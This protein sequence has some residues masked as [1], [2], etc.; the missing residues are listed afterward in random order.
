MVL[1]LW[2]TV[3]HSIPVLIISNCHFLRIYSTGFNAT[4]IKLY[5]TV[6]PYK[7]VFYSS[8][9][10][11]AS[12]PASM[13]LAGTETTIAASTARSAV[14]PYSVWWSQPLKSIQ[15]HPAPLCSLCWSQDPQPSASPYTVPWGSF[16]PSSPFTP[17][18]WCTTTAEFCCQVHPVM[19]IH[20]Q[21]TARWVQIQIFREIRECSLI[22]MMGGLVIFSKNIQ[23]YAPPL[24]GI[25]DQ[26]ASFNQPNLNGHPPVEYESGGV[27]QYTFISQTC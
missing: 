14:H 15:L 16:I 23:D 9:R 8:R 6:S 1:R 4:C 13:M 27:S 19:I 21:Y 20:V 18:N 11:Q 24:E 25:H 10:C 12:H 22:M 3:A 5:S 17:V 7:C 26:P 2:Y